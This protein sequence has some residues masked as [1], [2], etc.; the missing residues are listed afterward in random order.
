MKKV[1]LLTDVNFWERFSGN[2]MRIYNLIEYLA[3]LV[4]LTVINTGPAPQDIENQL[5]LK[6]K[7]EF[8]VLEKSRYLSSTGYGRKLKALIR[9]RQ[10]DAVIVEYIH[11]SYFLNFLEFDTKVILDAH[12]IISDRAD[13]FK[14]FNYPGTL[15]E[16]S[17][18]SENEIFNVYDYVMALCKPDYEKI[19]SIIGV[20]KS[21]L[22]PH[23][24]VPCRHPIRE[25]VETI[26]YV[27]SAYLPNRDAITF[28]LEN[29]WPK[30]SAKYPVQLLIYGAVGNEISLS[31]Y[32]RVRCKGYM[33]D[34]IQIYQNADIMINPVR[35]GAG[36]KIKNIEALANG[37]PLVT[38]SHG[39]RGLEAAINTAMLVAD[40]P[41]DIVSAIYHLIDRLTLRQDLSDKAYT[42]IDD[43]FSFESCFRSLIDVINL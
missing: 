32:E 40:S 2:R 1:L 27:A 10:F 4:E 17:R 42:F 6:F 13:E 11:S 35:F 7:A 21:L 24:V 26:A 9:K 14:K 19:G 30:I 25:K 18:E 22:C 3:P 16:I 33:A 29:C 8:H 5:S 31:G 20:E 36:L 15:Y 41:E 34:S 12:D 43:H 28:F 38:S 37:L 23:P 39:A